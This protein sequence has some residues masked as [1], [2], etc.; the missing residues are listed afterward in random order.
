MTILVILVIL[1]ILWL[2]IKP[3]FIKHDTV[4]LY[5]GGLGSGKTLVGVSD[6]LKC[7]RRNRNKVRWHNLMHPKNKK[8]KPLLYSTIPI[9]ISKREK[10]VDLNVDHV[11]LREKI[12]EKSVV[13]IDEAST[14]ANHFETVANNKNLKTL[15]EW[16]TFYRHYTKGGYLILTTQNT[17]KCNYTIR[18]CCNSAFQLSQFHS[19]PIPFIG[20]YWVKIRNIDLTN[21]VVNVSEN[22]VEDNMRIKIGFFGRRK[23]D[24]YAFSDRYIP[25]PVGENKTSETLKRNDFIDIP[26]TYLESRIN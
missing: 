14:V 2:I 24:T 19:V 16:S 26:R 17:A 25:V 5:V 21:D 22:N 13:F 18:Y 7:L 10:S 1:F 6:S 20:F 15:E 9:Q 3:Y 23:Y 4:V 12:V 8:P 11:L